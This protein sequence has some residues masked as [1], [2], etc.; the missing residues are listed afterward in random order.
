MAGGNLLRKAVPSLDNQEDC[1]VIS[2]RRRDSGGREKTHEDEQEHAAMTGSR[3]RRN[4]VAPYMASMLL[5][6]IDALP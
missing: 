1:G 2:S 3:A 6:L 4:G 5:V